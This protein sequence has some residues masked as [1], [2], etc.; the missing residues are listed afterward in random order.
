MNKL[1][2]LCRNN[3]DWPKTRFCWNNRNLTIID[4]PHL[5]QLYNIRRN[6]QICNISS[7]F[8]HTRP[9]NPS[10]VVARHHAEKMNTVKEL[11][12]RLNTN[13]NFHKKKQAAGMCLEASCVYAWWTML[14]CK[15][16]LYC[17][18][19]LWLQRCPCWCKGSRRECLLELSQ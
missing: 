10:E 6:C 14:W 12:T 8:V 16:W 11:A 4:D 5:Q 7:H 19:L 3:K 17:K 9:N 2:N 13:I 18:L 1:N 15:V